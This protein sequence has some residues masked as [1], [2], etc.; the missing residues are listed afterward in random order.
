M[1]QNLC[2]D[3]ETKYAQSSMDS[4]NEKVFNRFPASLKYFIESQHKL[5]YEKVKTMVIKEFGQDGLKS[6][7]KSS[8]FRAPRLNNYVGGVF[9][10]LH[11]WGCAI[12]F[13][14]VG[15]FKDKPI[16]VCSSLQCLDSGSCWHVQLKR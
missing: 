1:K 16:P 12:D 15:I 2:Y 5:I 3:N 13:R 6:L 14:K 8:G 10:S 9:D 4:E 7:V 11:I